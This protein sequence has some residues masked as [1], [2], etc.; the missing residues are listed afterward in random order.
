VIHTGVLDRYPNLDL[1][2]HHTGGN[3]ATMLGRYHNQL[4][5]FFPEERAAAKGG[6]L[7]APVKGY[8]EFEAQPADRVYV[9]T[10]GY[11]GYHNVIQ[12]ALS[13]LPTSQLVFGT[14]FP[15]ETRTQADFADMISVIERE[16]GRPD[17]ERI[18]SGNA[19]RVLGD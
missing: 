3:V 6:S 19:L 16:V 17:A 4:E 5:K 8:A 7:D 14:D 13:Q 2:F 10:A 9:D 1:V 18:L 11:Y 12:G 15:F